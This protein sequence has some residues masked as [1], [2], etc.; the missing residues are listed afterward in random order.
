VT[1]QVT[2]DVW[3]AAVTVYL[4]RL[5][6][7]RP[8]A[9]MPAGIES[10]LATWFRRGVHAYA[11]ARALTAVPWPGRAT[12]DSDPLVPENRRRVVRELRERLVA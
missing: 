6:C 8:L 11:V 3:V 12:L 2:F 5:Q 1:I 7:P 4:D 9:E 10:A